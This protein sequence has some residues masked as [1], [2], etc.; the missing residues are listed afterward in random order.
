M[1]E[2][3]LLP[4]TYIGY[5]RT[6]TDDKGQDPLRQ[7]DV[8][9]RWAEGVASDGRPRQVV[10]WVIDEGTSGGT[11]PFQRQHVLEAINLAEENHC[12]GIVVEAVD[13]WTRE[14]MR[15]L[16]LTEFFLDLDHKLCLEVADLPPGMDEF[17]REIITGLMAACAREFRRRLRESVTAG[18]A[19]AKAKGWPR[20]RPG[21]KPKP[22]FSDREKNLI[23]GMVFEEGLGV[24]KIAL[25]LSKLRGAWDCTDFKEQQRRRCG[26]T[27]TW[28]KIHET[29]PNTAA[30]LRRRCKTQNRGNRS[31][32]PIRK[33]RGQMRPF[34]SRY[35]K[36]RLEP[37]TNLVESESLAGGS[38]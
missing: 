29:M 20:G 31:T 27:W 18:L 6:S 10:A 8:I 11:D 12:D 34:Q 9:E 35:A 3:E 14:G 28:H 1:Q 37:L 17:T 26:P 25:E 2:T 13:R 15:K 22:G 36:A 30:E 33:S 24:D 32:R 7:R 16:A 21:R 4:R 19:R 5:C 38:A 23:R